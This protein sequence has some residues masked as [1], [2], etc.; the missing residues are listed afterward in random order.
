MWRR[1]YRRDKWD[2]IYASGCRLISFHMNLSYTVS[3]PIT[4]PAA[5]MTAGGFFPS[6]SLLRSPSQPVRPSTTCTQTLG[7]WGRTRTLLFPQASA[8]GRGAY[9][10][11]YLRQE[12]GARS[13]VYSA[14]RGYEGRPEV[15]SWLGGSSPPSLSVVRTRPRRRTPWRH[16]AIF[17]PPDGRPD[18]APANRTPQPAH[19]RTRRDALERRLSL[20]QD[21]QIIPRD[22]FSLYSH[23]SY[24]SGD[25]LARPLLLLRKRALVFT[26]FPPADTF[27][28][29]ASQPAGQPTGRRPATFFTYHLSSNAV[30]RSEAP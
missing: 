29:P 26:S 4:G 2:G 17:L 27:G 6:S 16:G 28:Q 25:A 13:S 21:G 5:K 12:G 14:P 19:K 8:E 10:A 9:A 18:E 1:R 11:K 15:G 30:A 22:F 3:D 20:R 7:V 23:P 24:P